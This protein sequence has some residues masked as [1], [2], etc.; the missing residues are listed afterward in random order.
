M[1]PRPA[2]SEPSAPEAGGFLVVASGHAV[3]VGPR[4]WSSSSRSLPGS[5]WWSFYPRSFRKWRVVTI[6]NAITS[7]W[8]SISLTGDVGLS[9]LSL[10]PRRGRRTHPQHRLLPGARCR[11]ASAQGAGLSYA[12]QRPRGADLIVERKADGSIPLLKRLPPEFAWRRRPPRRVPL[13]QRQHLGS[14]I[15][16][17]RSA[18]IFSACQSVRA[19]VKDQFVTPAL[20][21][22]LEL[23]L[24]LTDLGSSSRPQQVHHG[25]EQRRTARLPARRKARARARRRPSMRRC[26]SIPPACTC[27]PPPGT[28]RRWGC[29]RPREGI[30]LRLDAS[31]HATPSSQPGF[32]RG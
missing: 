6:S 32:C 22:Q 24:R 8:S 17:R 19:H 27:V 9:H 3:S 15:S 20:D 23:N 28:S 16:R 14:S 21:T 26:A 1:R 11:H 4:R 25:S 2:A 12:V 10:T 7:E 31:I 29:K 5:S 30:S 13:A 18:S